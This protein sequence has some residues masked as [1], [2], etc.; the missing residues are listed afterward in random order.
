[1]YAGF[2][3]NCHLLPWQRRRDL[4]DKAIQRFKRISHAS[5][6]WFAVHLRGRRHRALARPNRGEVWDSLLHRL[7]LASEVP[8]DYREVRLSSLAVGQIYNNE[9]WLSTENELE[10]RVR[11]ERNGWRRFEFEW[12]EVQIFFGFVLCVLLQWK[13]KIYK[14]GE[15]K[16][17]YVL[18]PCFRF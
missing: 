11:K 16:I 6:L 14:K 2:D 9:R 3:R 8:Q 5:S 15:M 13:Y 1:M 7:G 17:K 10:K 4:V 18:N 12:N